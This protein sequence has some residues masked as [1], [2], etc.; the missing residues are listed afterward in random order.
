MKLC[1]DLAHPEPRPSRWGWLL[2]GVGVAAA[3]WAGW[4]HVQETGRV[5]AAR[6]QLAAL[7]PAPAKAARPARDAARESALA[8]NARRALEA[9][10]ARLLMGLENSRPQ[11]IALLSVEADAAQGRL[12]LEANARDLPAMLAYLE[13]LE[14]LGLRRVHLQSH[15]AMEE[16]GQDTIHFTATAGWGVAGAGP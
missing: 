11:P 16:E 4:R 9:D 3:L 7:T 8:V 1:L 14:A 5:E 2:L 10:W 13:G 15:V 12:R 6:E